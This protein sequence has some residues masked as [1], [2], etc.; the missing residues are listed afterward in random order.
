[1]IAVLKFEDEII[2]KFPNLINSVP[3]HILENYSSL[4]RNNDINTIDALIDSDHLGPSTQLLI[5]ANRDDTHGRSVVL[6][7]I[8][9]AMGADPNS[10]T[11]TNGYGIGHLTENPEVIAM[12]IFHGYDIEYR[13]PLEGD[14]LE[15]YF[16]TDPQFADDVLDYLTSDPAYFNNGRTPVENIQLWIQNNS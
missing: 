7:R 5:A 3:F 15:D 9:L 1:M 6:V 2:S 14:S 13:D 4:I 16:H 12:A 8:L 11:G 10:R